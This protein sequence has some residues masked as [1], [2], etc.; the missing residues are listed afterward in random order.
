MNCLPFELERKICEMATNQC[1]YPLLPTIIL[2]ARRFREWS[3]LLVS[4]NKS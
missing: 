1:Q 4:E 2:V 3:V